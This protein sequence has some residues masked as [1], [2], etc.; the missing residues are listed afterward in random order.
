MQ[1][2]YVYNLLKQKQ[3]IMEQL[4]AIFSISGPLPTSPE[5]TLVFSLVLALSDEFPWGHTH[6]AGFSLC[7]FFF[8]FLKNIYSS[9]TIFFSTVQ[10]GDPVTHTCT[11]SIFSHYQAPS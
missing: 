3:N 11:H 2:V 6:A 4:G 8:A 10:H 7:F 1:V 5:V 9:N